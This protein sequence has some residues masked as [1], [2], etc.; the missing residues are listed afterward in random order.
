MSIQLIACTPKEFFKNWLCDIPYSEFS[1][2]FISTVW[3]NTNVKIRSFWLNG[4][5]SED[6]MTTSMSK[7]WDLIREESTNGKKID[8]IGDV[9]LPTNSH[10]RKEIEFRLHWDNE[11]PKKVYAT[12]TRD[13]L[14]DIKALRLVMK[15]KGG[16]Y[17]N[18]LLHLE[19]M[20]SILKYA[21]CRKFPIFWSF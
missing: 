6:L 10:L 15:K 16:D 2:D 4:G 5:R 20:E 9:C 21:K 17:E 18:E 13:A 14:D 3:S 8:L 19:C 7:I 1:R 11:G 12:S